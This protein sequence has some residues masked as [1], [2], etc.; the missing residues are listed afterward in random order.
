MKKLLLVLLLISVS[1]S[2]SKDDDDTKVTT[3]PLIGV[4]T[5]T[6]T[7][8]SGTYNI[9]SNGTYIYAEES[10]KTDLYEGEWSNDGT[11]FNSRNQI[12]SL[13]EDNYP[14]FKITA[15]F[16]SDFNSLEFFKEED[17]IYVRQ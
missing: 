1:V 9:N 17:N 12:Y 2:C 4:W 16:S 11:D 10:G 8:I 6:Y 13:T 7:T 14:S 3:D 15:R 5:Y